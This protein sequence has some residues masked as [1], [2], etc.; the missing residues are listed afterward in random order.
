MHTN[1]NKFS[2]NI[3]NGAYDHKHGNKK[4]INTN[5]S[6]RQV[7]S[8]GVI[9]LDSDEDGEDDEIV[10]LGRMTEDDQKA[11]NAN[12]TY[13][14]RDEKVVKQKDGASSSACSS[15]VQGSKEAKYISNGHTSSTESSIGPC[16]SSHISDTNNNRDD[17]TSSHSSNL[18]FKRTYLESQNDNYNSHKIQCEICNLM[19]SLNALDYHMNRHEKSGDILKHN[20][21]K[22]YR[23]SVQEDILKNTLKD[24]NERMEEKKRK[25][26]EDE[27]ELSEIMKASK[28][29]YERQ[30]MEKFKNDLLP[31]PLLGPS[32]RIRFYLHI[33]M[34][35]STCVFKYFCIYTCMI[36][37]LCAIRYLLI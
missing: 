22:E 20:Q 15:N 26:I 28:E 23:E 29:A 31:E 37:Y 8:N 32:I 13:D 35:I 36:I 16:K 25:N 7:C 17:N 3:N 11:T 19:V 6:K 14:I 27:T 24:E 21:D 34:H 33:F 5:N 4:S 30:E 12:R 1:G 9:N 10:F 18:G 2:N